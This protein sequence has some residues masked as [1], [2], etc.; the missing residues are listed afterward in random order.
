MSEHNSLVS[1]SITAV[2]ENSK[3]FGI[4]GAVIGA[5]LVIYYCSVIEFYP[6]GLT[7][8]DTLFFLWAVIVFGF[9]YTFIAGSFFIASS[10]W[11]VLLAKPINFL[12]KKS[13]NKRNIVVPLPKNDLLII[14]GT[15]LSANILI[16]GVT[17]LTGQVLTPVIVALFLIGLIYTLLD[18]TS[19]RDLGNIDLLD[20]SGKPIYTKQISP[21]TLKSVF[22]IMIYA[23]PL[24]FGQVGTGVTR[25]T[26]K[27]MGILQ[28][29]VDVSI[30]SHGYRTIF[31]EYKEKGFLPNVKCK[32]VCTFQNV[33]ILFTNI[34]LNTKIEVQ[35]K[36]GSATL[37]FPSKIIRLIVKTKPYKSLNTEM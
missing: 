25:S 22:I 36:K 31:N 7:I 8:A 17:Y 15:G 12:L 33:K 5:L 35:G 20:S 26:F 27:T 18:N 6:T 37:V 3:T 30:D 34:G 32:D 9:Y 13:D 2:K 24:L 29:G 21:S 10:F 19:K 23:A 4:T 28:V 16:L 1:K 14:I 11:V